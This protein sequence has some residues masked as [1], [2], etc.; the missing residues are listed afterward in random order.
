MDEI[1]ASFKQAT[2]KGGVIELKFEVLS[3]APGAFDVTRKTGSV[4]VLGVSPVQKELGF[5]A[6]GDALWRP[7]KPANVDCETGEVYEV[8]EDEA[9]MLEGGEWL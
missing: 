2:V 8:I 1:R 3:D 7:G 5:E 9:R 6:E 4:V